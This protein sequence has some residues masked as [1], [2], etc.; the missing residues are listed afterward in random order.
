MES[1]LGSDDGR[2]G[3]GI[4]IDGA[5]GA[6]NIFVIDGINTTSI[7]TGQSAKTLIT[8]FVEEVQVK[9]SGYNAEFGGA[10][11]GVINVITKSG[12]NSF[13]GDGGFYYTGNN[14]AGEVRP[15]LRI[16][17]TSNTIAEYVTYPDDT[18]SR[19]E[20]GGSV[21]GPLMSDKAWFFVGYMPSLQTSDRTAPLSN[22]V[23]TTQTRKD[24]THNFTANVSSQIS[25]KVRGKF[26]VNLDNFK[27]IG[28]LPEPGWHDEPARA[29]QFGSDAAG[30]DLLRSARLR[31][32]QSLL[33]GGALGLLQIRPARLW[34][35]GRDALGVPDHEHRPGRGAGQPA[36]RAPFFEH[37]DEL[38]VRVRPLHAGGREHRCDLL[39]ELR[40]PAYVQGRLPAR[41]VRQRRAQRRA[42]AAHQPF[43][44]QHATARTS[45]GSTGARSATTRGASS[46]PRG[47]CRATR[48]G[49]TSRTPGR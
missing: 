2:H 36:E 28:L 48:W 5:S 32:Q 1:K 27:R 23:S 19:W 44:G 13:R 45:A 42:A 30:R 10:M 21:G 18:L 25:E 37:S 29:L 6:E 35:A 41:S 15:T 20:P 38:R 22:G 14:M 49:S 12:S 4:S 46:R 33:P 7:R 39:R 9:S 34:R 16:S 11:G 26:A 31:R 3:V 8:D 24:R 47:A 43:L 17:P 40:R